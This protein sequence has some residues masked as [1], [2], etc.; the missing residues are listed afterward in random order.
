RDARVRLRHLSRRVGLGEGRNL[1]LE[2]AEG[3]YVSFLHTTDLL[4][5]GSLSA[6]DQRLRETNPDV[7]LTHHFCTDALGDSR[8][9]RY[10]ELLLGIANEGIAWLE[11]RPAIAQAAPHAWSTFFKRQFLRDIGV[12]FGHGGYS[13]LRGTWP[14]L[15]AAQAI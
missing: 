12:R 10:H 1:A 6:V 14:A 8:P 2:I 7:L 9:G 4:S 11:Q 5:P 13:E 3:D 15:L